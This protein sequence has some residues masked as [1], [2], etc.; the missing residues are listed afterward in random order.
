MYHLEGY[1]KFKLGRL[2]FCS[3]FSINSCSIGLFFNKNST[4]DASVNQKLTHA[5]ISTFVN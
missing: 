5:P 3:N 1:F 2:K 4:I